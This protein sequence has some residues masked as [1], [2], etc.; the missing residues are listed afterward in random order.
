M[1]KSFSS[2]KDRKQ[3]EEQIIKDIAKIKD[4]LNKNQ[5]K[6]DN[7]SKKQ[8]VMDVLTQFLK[9]KKDTKIH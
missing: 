1:K 6:Q 5:L 2:K 7:Q 9:L 3:A 8:G 4:G